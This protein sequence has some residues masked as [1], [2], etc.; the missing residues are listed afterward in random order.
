MT[1]GHQCTA[2]IDMNDAIAL[3]TR[4]CIAPAPERKVHRLLT[5]DFTIVVKHQRLDGLMPQRLHAQQ[6][7]RPVGSLGIVDMAV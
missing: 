1:W 2:D 3:T 4:E 7:A 6:I 5:A